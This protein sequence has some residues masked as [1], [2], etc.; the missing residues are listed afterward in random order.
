M[1]YPEF[2]GGEFEPAKNI[3]K[4]KKNELNKMKQESNESYDKRERNRSGPSNK[5]R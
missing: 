4:Q 1:I 3:D 5:Q 2:T